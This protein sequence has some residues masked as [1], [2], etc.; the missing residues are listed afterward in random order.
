MCQNN[1]NIKERKFKHINYT[2]RTQIERWY[3]KDKKS[4]VE[5]GKLLGRPE[6]SIRR[7]IKRGLVILQFIFVYLRF[8]YLIGKFQPQVKSFDYRV[9]YIIKI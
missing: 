4:K 2:E 1:N 3:N 5:I 8:F 9:L 7:E 6:S